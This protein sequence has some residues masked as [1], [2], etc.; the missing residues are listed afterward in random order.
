MLKIRKFIHRFLFPGY[1][2]AM[3][4][5]ISEIDFYKRQYDSSNRTSISMAKTINEL[6]ER[7]KK[8]SDINEMENIMRASLG[9]PYIRFDNIERDTDGNDNPPH[10]LKGLD[11]DERKAYINELSTI[12]KNPK[13]KE[14]MNYQINVLG[15]HS[16]QKAGDADMRNGRIGIIAL[17][18]FRKS[19]EDANKEYMDSLKEE[20]N[21]DDHAVLPE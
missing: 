13:F 17:R 12:F 11:P 3:K 18:A 9:L 7:L 21:F 6:E 20:E 2:D 4:E 1:A 14:V 8:K 16:I 15:N 19:F 10:Y 5:A